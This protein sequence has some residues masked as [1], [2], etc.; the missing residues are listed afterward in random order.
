MDISEQFL[1]LNLSIVSSVPG[2]TAGFSGRVR[3][4][5]HLFRYSP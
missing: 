1:R 5:L 4:A 3:T 2:V